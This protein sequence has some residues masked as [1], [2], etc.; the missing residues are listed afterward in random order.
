MKAMAKHRTH[1]IEFKRQ[2]A[3]DFIAG[4]NASCCRQ[5]AR[6]LAQPYPNLGAKF[7]AG[8]FDDDT[9]AADLLPDYEA[10]IAVLERLV[11]GRPLKSS[12]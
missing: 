6:P 1:S 8:A 12:F 5:P 2:I 9:R 10:K 3:Q 7:E 11:G 4:E